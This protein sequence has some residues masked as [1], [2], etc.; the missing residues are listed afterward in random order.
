MTTNRRTG[1][2]AKLPTI[3]G[4]VRVR[5]FHR[6]LP[7]TKNQ[8]QYWLQWFK[9]YK[10][11]NTAYYDESDIEVMRHMGT[12]I[13]AL[14]LPPQQALVFARKFVKTGVVQQDRKW[15]QYKGVQIGIPV[16]FEV[17]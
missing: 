14:S 4:K 10:V 17:H 8:V 6:Q 9:P 16:E 13:Y 2:N 7:F 1:K 3:E 11:R 15:I 5:E 12:L